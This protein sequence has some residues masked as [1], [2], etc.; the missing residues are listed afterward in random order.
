MWNSKTSKIQKK[1]LIVIKKIIFENLL[2]HING[3]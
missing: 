2:S 3:A 1:S